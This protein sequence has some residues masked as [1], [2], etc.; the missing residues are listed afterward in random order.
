MKSYKE[1]GGGGEVREVSDVTEPVRSFFKVCFSLQVF[2]H[3]LL[4]PSL[5]KKH[6]DRQTP[7]TEEEQ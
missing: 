7:T 6:I 1:G 5:G 4:L 3:I 2:P